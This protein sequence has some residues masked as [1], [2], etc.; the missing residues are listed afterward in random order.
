MPKKVV[1][2]TQ[3]GVAFK[4]HERK[5]PTPPVSP[6]VPPAKKSPTVEKKVEVPSRVARV[7]K[8]ADEEDELEAKTSVKAVAEPTTLV[9]VPA[10][11]SDVQVIEAPLVKK[12]KLKKVAKPDIRATKPAALVIEPAAKVIETAAPA[13]KAVNI[14][15][16]LVARRKQAPHPSML[17]MAD[18]EAF[19]ANE[20][21]LVELV[22]VVEPVVEGP[23]RA[24]E[25]HIPSVLNHPLGSNIQHILEDLDLKLEESVGMADDNMGPFVSAA[26]KT[27]QRPLSPILEVGASSRAPTPKRPRSLTHA[28]VD[29]ASSSKRP[30]A[31]ETSEAFR[32]FDSESSAKIQPEWA[33]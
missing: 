4:I 19:L 23:L 13:A 29:R 10:E 31:F 28:G 15:F 5:D 7:L 26:T 25:G 33:N 11:E 6:I 27:P 16:F 21:V 9:S 22:N 20:P 17:R 30:W 2:R 14:A 1:Y 18:V 8:L 32:A 12:R 24:P 3:T